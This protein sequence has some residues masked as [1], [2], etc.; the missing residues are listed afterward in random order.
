MRKGRG[1]PSH[2]EAG[3]PAGY[4]DWLTHNSRVKWGVN[5]QPPLAV[6]LRRQAAAAPLLLLLL[7]SAHRLTI[8]VA[9]LFASQTHE[10]LEQLVWGKILFDRLQMS[11]LSV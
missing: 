4:H 3:R 7:E 5:F 1:P 9:D 6:R 2:E 10:M 8:I 11:N